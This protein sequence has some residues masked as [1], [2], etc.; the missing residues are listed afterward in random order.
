MEKGER[1]GDL[2]IFNVH[3]KPGESDSFIASR[4]GPLTEDYAV[5][6]FIPGVGSSHVALILAGITTIGTQAAVEFVCRATALE[7]LFRHL[8]PS[9][10]EPMQHFEALARV[11]VS[12]GVPVNTQLIAVHVRGK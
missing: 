12:A 8:A 10:K 3:P 7:D 4:N 6:A 5:V 2:A 9:G 11:K 1:K